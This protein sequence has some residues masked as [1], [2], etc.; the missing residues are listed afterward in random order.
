MKDCEDMQDV[1][2]AKMANKISALLLIISLFMGLIINGDT[3]GCHHECYNFIPKDGESDT[4]LHILWKTDIKTFFPCMFSQY[5][6][7][8]FFYRFTFE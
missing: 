7:E 6:L 4:M 2:K 8:I 3:Q 5:S 1:N